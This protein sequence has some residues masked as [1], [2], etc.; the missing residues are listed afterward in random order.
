MCSNKAES[1]AL[2]FTVKKNIVDD[3]LIVLLETISAKGGLRPNGV[4]AQKLFLIEKV[5]DF[6]LKRAFL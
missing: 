3:S 4:L 2:V 1:T 5:L 6:S